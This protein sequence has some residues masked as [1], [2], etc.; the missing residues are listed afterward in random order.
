MLRP[1]RRARTGA[2]CLSAA[3]LL[4]GACADP[5]ISATEPE[6]TQ[7]RYSSGGPAEIALVTN[8]SNRDNWGAHSALIIDGPERVVFNPAGTWYH[9]ASPER[10]DVHYGFTP[11]ME[12]WFIDYH[13]RETYR[14]HIQRIQVP[15][16]VAAAA[17]ERARTYGRV[18]PARC[19]VAV[20]EILH[21]LPGFEDF[22]VV[23]FPDRAEKAFARYDGVETTIYVDDSPGDRSDLDRGIPR[24]STV[25]AV[26]QHGLA[27][28]V[29]RDL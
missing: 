4:L 7:S 9:P 29:P 8:V 1:F 5:E 3:L 22:P 12:A 27:E 26:P 21:G 19:T 6:I 20:T 28:A 15:P 23:W 24:E 10:G 17:L 13:A 14:V 18:G 25:R 16:E 2:A 11:E